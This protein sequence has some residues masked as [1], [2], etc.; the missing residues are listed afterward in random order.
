[1]KLASTL[2]R[3]LLL[4]E[5]A[6]RRRLLYRN[7][8]SD[9]SNTLCGDPTSST[10]RSNWMTLVNTMRQRT[11][12]KRKPMHQRALKH[13]QNTQPPPNQDDDV[14]IPNITTEPLNCLVS[15]RHVFFM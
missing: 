11:S 5:R 4:L 3:Y 6:L 1:M 14:A 13:T 9:G 2:F 12:A 15:L 8:L 7:A 10:T